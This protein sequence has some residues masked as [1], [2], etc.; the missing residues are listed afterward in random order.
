MA[1]FPFAQIFLNRP[2]YLPHRYVLIF[3]FLTI[4][5]TCAIFSPLIFGC[6]TEEILTDP[7]DDHIDVRWTWISEKLKRADYRTWYFGKGHHGFESVKHFPRHKGFDVHT[8]ILNGADSYRN[9]FVWDEF[10]PKHVKLYSTRFYAK[11]A[12]Q[13][14]DNHFLS[15]DPRPFFLFLS[16]QTPHSPLDPPNP[17]QFRSEQV[18]SEVRSR[19]KK[20][21]QMMYTVDVELKNLAELLRLHGAWNNT[22]FAFISD[23]GATTSRS[24]G[25]NWPLRGEKSTSFEGAMRVT[26]FVAGGFVPPRLH[27][28]RNGV[29]SHI[30]DWYATFCYLAGVDASDDSPEAIRHENLTAESISPYHPVVKNLLGQEE[31]LWGDAYPGVDSVN[32]V[33]FLYEPE[34]YSAA[35]AHEYLVLSTEVIIHGDFKLITAQPCALDT[36]HPV[37]NTCKIKDNQLMYGWIKLDDERWKPIDDNRLGC[38]QV[39]NPHRYPS[40]SMLD[41]CLFDLS[42]DPRE[43]NPVQNP[44]VAA[45]LWR[46]LND[47]LLYQ[48]TTNIPGKEEGISPQGCLG[49]CKSL[50]FAQQRF[51]VDADQNEVPLCGLEYVQDIGALFC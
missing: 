4:E 39:F 48:Y 50:K 37:P 22:V 42:V 51:G 41:P 49:I 18:Y 27:G 1:L 24:E 16:F 46:K 32:L 36:D 47:T 15:G 10:E 44:E 21:D 2:A 35:S 34:K 43:E 7:F 11:Q 28:T 45:K 23:N 33:P 17:Q 31:N 29:N 26:G 40:E 3:G 30:A 12:Y 5:G 20:L 8:G 9:S 25:S 14:V 6:S 38:L 19:W 13:M